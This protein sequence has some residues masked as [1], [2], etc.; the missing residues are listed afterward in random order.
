[1]T[2]GHI[3]READFHGETVIVTR[4]QPVGGNAVGCSSHADA[5]TDFL[6]HTPQQ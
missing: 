4:H 1:M 5:V 6:L 2:R 3:A